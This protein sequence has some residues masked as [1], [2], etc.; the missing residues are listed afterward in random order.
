MS[1]AKT[2]TLSFRIEPHLKEML[3]TVAEQEHRS[4][5]NMVEIMIREYCGQVGVV[6][7]E[8]EPTK[9]SGKTGNPISKKSP[10]AKKST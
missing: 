2:A 7:A 8:H 1:I 9:N 4:I 5:A 10:K 3:R 6:I